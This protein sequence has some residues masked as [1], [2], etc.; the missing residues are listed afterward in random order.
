MQLK[1]TNKE[2]KMELEYKKWRMIK[3]RPSRHEGKHIDA[4]FF[5]L[6][7]A[8]LTYTS[9]HDFLG[10]A[11]MNRTVNSTDRKALIHVV[12]FEVK[13]CPICKGWGKLD[14][15][16]QATGITGISDRRPRQ[17]EKEYFKI[18]D[19]VVKHY[20]IGKSKVQYYTSIPLLDEGEK[21]CYQCFGCGID[22]HQPHGKVTF[23][24]SLGHTYQKVIS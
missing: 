20:A 4:V 22:I 11:Q 12:N 3:L 13:Y 2:G 17:E 7:W 16:Q 18:S 9:L 15:I 1:L 24:N 19:E 23:Y 14:W 10:K 6:I 5:P 8:R 21:V